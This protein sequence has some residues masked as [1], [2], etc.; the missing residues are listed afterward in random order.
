MNGW[1]PR[2]TTGAGSVEPQTGEGAAPTQVQGRRLHNQGS[3]NISVAPGPCRDW[4]PL[5]NVHCSQVLMQ[6]TTTVLLTRGGTW[7]GVVT[8]VETTLL[9]T[10]RNCS[11][12]LQQH[13]CL[14]SPVPHAT[15]VN[16]DVTLESSQSK[17]T[18]S[19]DTHLCDSP[20]HRAST[21]STP[22]TT[23]LST[24]LNSREWGL[25]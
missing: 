4:K 8:N 3:V 9:H 22:T 25:P 24:G 19:H 16:L 7:C 14:L 6:G 13:R 11:L 15:Q 2:V 12:T 1:E 20:I 21:M 23:G 10:H 5:S 17:S 18:H